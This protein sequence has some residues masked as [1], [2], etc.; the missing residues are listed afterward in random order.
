MHEQVPRLVT[1]E[2][3]CAAAA[4]GDGRAALPGV[5]TDALRD[6]P[7]PLVLTDFAGRDSVA[8]AMAWL[9]THEVGTLLP[10][11]DV[12][13]TRFGDW[14][15]YDSN[16]RSLRDQ[17]GRR[18]PDVVVA[19]WFVMEDVDA[20]RLLNGRYLNELIGAFGF[21]TPCLGCHLHFYMMRTVLAQVVGATALISGEK[22]LHRQG[23][24]KANQTRE[25]VAAYGRFSRSHGLNQ[26]FP[27]H[28]VTS[29]DEMGRLLGDGWQEGERQLP[30]VNSGNDRGLD[31]QLLMTP[32]QIDAYM[33]RF[34]VPLATRLVE[35]RKQGVSGAEL[36][37]RVDQVVRALLRG[38]P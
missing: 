38:E 17:V 6:A 15:V 29:E 22:E 5:V 19:P 2:A 33:H 21:F 13:P 4:R 12:V 10:V 34:A 26:Q 20:W 28:G 23:K 35:F 7:T 8:A 18:F 25:A 24:R 32:E 37:A 3:L 11:G 27:I 36:Q 14:S 31:G 9:E 16:W 1:F 30:C